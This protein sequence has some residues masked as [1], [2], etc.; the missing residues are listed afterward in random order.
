M[1]HIQQDYANDAINKLLLEIKAKY[2]NTK[3]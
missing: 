2:K 3:E 1:N